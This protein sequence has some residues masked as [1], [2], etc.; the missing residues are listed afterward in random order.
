[1]PTDAASTEYPL[2]KIFPFS[3]DS[4]CVVVSEVGYPFNIS[5]PLITDFAATP[6]TVSVI[7]YPL[8]RIFPRCTVSAIITFSVV[9]YPLNRIFPRSIDFV[10]ITCS[11]IS[12]P[13]NN[14]LPFCTCSDFAA[15]VAIG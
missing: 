11:V 7:G 14:R 9:S 4:F 12:Y 2:N 5:L 15:T 3:T 8:N 1:M 6:P 13:L 10:F